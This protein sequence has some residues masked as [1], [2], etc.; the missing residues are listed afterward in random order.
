MHFVKPSI[1]VR[2]LKEE[3]FSFVKESDAQVLVLSN[4]PP[5]YF[6][7]RQV[8]RMHFTAHANDAYSFQ[9]R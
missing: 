9:L 3:A 8:T 5:S 1:S 6:Q 7:E 2:L 4:L